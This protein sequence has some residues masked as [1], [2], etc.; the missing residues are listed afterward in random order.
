MT[1]EAMRIAIAALCEWDVHHG[2]LYV[3]TPNLRTSGIVDPLADLNACAY[4]KAH[5]T[6]WEYGEY[7]DGLYDGG[8]YDADAKERSTLFLKVKGK[9]VE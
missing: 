1:N 4:F 5:M 6:E 9:W 7:C 3:S 8:G 2:G